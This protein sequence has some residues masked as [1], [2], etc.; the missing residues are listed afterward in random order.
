MNSD[1]I[2]IISLNVVEYLSFEYRKSITK[3]NSMDRPSE[4]RQ[5]CRRIARN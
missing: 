3:R 4:S 1:P 2:I 5:I